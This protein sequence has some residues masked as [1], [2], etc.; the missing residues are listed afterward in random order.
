MSGKKRQQRA[1][2]RSR[3]RIRAYLYGSDRESGTSRGASF[4]GGGSGAVAC[5]KP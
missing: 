4:A 3:E 5:G 1:Q 2:R